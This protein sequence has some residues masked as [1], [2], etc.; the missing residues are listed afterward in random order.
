[1]LYTETKSALVV[2]VGVLIA[3]GGVYASGY[4]EAKYPGLQGT[5]AKKTATSGTTS[6]TFD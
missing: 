3:T 6:R 1:M 5:P 2:V 4:S